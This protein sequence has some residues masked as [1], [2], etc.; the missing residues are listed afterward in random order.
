ML[1]EETKNCAELSEK[2]LKEMCS[3]GYS[4]KSVDHHVKP[5]YNTLVKYCDE[6]FEG[7]YSVKCELCKKV[8]LKSIQGSKNVII[9][10]RLFPLLR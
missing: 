1:K 5:I 7:M 9:S 10:S 2:M 4:R 3:D 6:H 8:T